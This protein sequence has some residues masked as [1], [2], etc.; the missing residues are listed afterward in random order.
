MAYAGAFVTGSLATIQK[1]DVPL[2]GL[3]KSKNNLASSWPTDS[4]YHPLG[5]AMKRLSDTI[6]ETK[7]RLITKPSDVATM[8]AIDSIFDR[9]ARRLPSYMTS[10]WQAA[11][12]RDD[13]HW[14]G[15]L[16]EYL[17]IAGNSLV[18]PFNQDTNVLDL[19]L[20]SIAPDW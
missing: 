17:A 19:P 6:Q 16:L 4:L 14:I 11:G 10:Q 7:L 5:M 9:H 18:R 20:S 13:T 12:K 1:L 3:I 8:M 2:N 15:S